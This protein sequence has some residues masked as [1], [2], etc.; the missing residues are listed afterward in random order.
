MP[1]LDY[2]NIKICPNKKGIYNYVKTYVSKMGVQITGH[3]TAER[4]LH[5]IHQIICVNEGNM[6]HKSLKIT[7][8]K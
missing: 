6:K 8:Q 5:S 2:R 7:D 3:Y 1:N 4:C